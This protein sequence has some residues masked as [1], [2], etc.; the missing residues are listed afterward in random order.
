M[1]RRFVTPL[2][3]NPVLSEEMYIYPPIYDVY[4]N[5]PIKKYTYFGGNLDTQTNQI[6]DLTKSDAVNNANYFWNQQQVGFRKSIMEITDNTFKFRGRNNCN[7][8]FSP[9]N[10]F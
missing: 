10:S 9:Y 8:N 7:D 2:N 6:P 3:Y 5:S 4:E 1:E